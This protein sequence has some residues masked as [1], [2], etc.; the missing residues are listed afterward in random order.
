MSDIMAE[1]LHQAVVDWGTK[2]EHD[3]KYP[4]CKNWCKERE[5]VDAYE[6]KIRETA[7]EVRG[8]MD[9]DE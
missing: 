4:N 2:E 7:D 3:Y 1:D 5:A 9:L 6:D 8:E